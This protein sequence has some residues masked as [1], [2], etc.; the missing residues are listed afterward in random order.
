[1]DRLVGQGKHVEDIYPL[2]PMQQGMLFHAL[3]DEGSGVYVEQLT[4]RIDAGL[5]ISAFKDAWNSV[6]RRHA[7]LRSAFVWEGLDTPLQIVHSIASVP[8]TEYDLR[9]MQTAD[10]EARIAAFMREDR[11]RGF[12][13]QVAPLT[14]ITLFRL[15]EHVPVCRE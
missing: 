13:V 11:A 14:R 7:T 3:R 15:D 4:F 1:M 8:W 2:S 6:Q 9:S 12:D 5:R 10:Q